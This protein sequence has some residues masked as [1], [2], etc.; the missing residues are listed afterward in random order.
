MISFESRWTHSPEETDHH[1]FVTQNHTDQFQD[2]VYQ[3]WAKTE[4]ISEQQQ[5]AITREEVHRETAESTNSRVVWWTLFEALALVSLAGFQV[6]YLRS[7]FE[8]KHII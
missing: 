6:Y 4:D 2:L 8:V 7:Y 1:S 5:F 3:L